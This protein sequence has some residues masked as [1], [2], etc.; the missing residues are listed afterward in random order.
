[1]NDSPKKRKPPRSRHTGFEVANEELEIEE[2]NENTFQL[3]EVDD[4]IEETEDDKEE[5]ISELKGQIEEL[6]KKIQEFREPLDA[7]KDKTRELEIK[8]SDTEKVVIELTTRCQGYEKKYFGL[9]KF[10]D[11]KSIA[12][13]TG[14]T[15]GEVFD[16]LYDFCDPGEDGENIR[17]WHSSSTSQDTTVVS[18][19]D[20][21][22]I[23]SIPKPGR[24]RL[25]HL[26]KERFITLC[27]LRQGFGEEHLAHLYGV[28]QARISRVIIT[29]VNVLYLRLKDV[30]MWPSR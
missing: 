11:G 29:W 17:Y 19:N 20:C 1:M 21:E 23:E 3:L 2:S 8:L 5:S 28:S 26:K 24:R 30:P 13:Y 15:C 9:N 12:F 7:E 25:L 22:F 27:R 14:F 18:E 16:A 10:K 4:H 6:E